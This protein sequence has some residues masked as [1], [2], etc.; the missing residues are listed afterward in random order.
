VTPEHPPGIGFSK[1]PPRG[2][3]VL[4]LSGYGFAG[5]EAF[6]DLIREF[7]GYHVEPSDFEFNLL[8]VPGGLLDLEASVV[9]GWSFIRSD[10]AARR[11]KRVIQRMGV[12]NRWTRPASWFQAVGM[13][14]DAHYHGRF[15]SLADQFLDEIVVSSWQ[16]EWPFA[17]TDLG[18]G[19]LFLRKLAVRM[20]ISRGG[21]FQVRL[22]RPEA[23]HEAARAFLTE[24]LA[25]RMGPE[26]RVAVLHNAFEPYNPSRCLSFFVAAR[27]IAIRR[28]PRDVFTEHART[29]FAPMR[30]S[31]DDFIPRF[32]AYQELSGLG[33]DGDSGCLRLRFEDLVFNYD[34]TV[35]AVL[36]HLGEPASTHARPRQFLRPEESSRN[37][38]IWKDHKNQAE[39]RRIERELGQY[40]WTQG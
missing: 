33:E 15:I 2:G 26:D 23:F 39:I 8:R 4:D 18:P 30:I 6:S 19:E 34:E 36:N 20:G 28:D 35:A 22:V 1:A 14:W 31:I 16:T 37:V 12:R 40:C 9:G 24:L 11:F 3:F 38:G 7:D 29:W 5:K 13:S 10:G 27:S 17:W 32:R 25:I 21:K